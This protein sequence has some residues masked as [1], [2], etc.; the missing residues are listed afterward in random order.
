M[1]DIITVHCPLNNETRNLINDERIKMM[2]KD[3]ILV[4]EARGAVLDETAVARAIL[5]GRIG[6][7]GSD[8]YS[9]EPFD[10][11]HPFAQISGLDN[12][13]LTPHAAWGAYEARVRCLDIICSNIKCFI[14]GKIQ[15]R[16]DI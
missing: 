4:N 14:D 3:V 12:V 16:V 6:A 9:K 8:V 1:S 2:K 11:K 13:C 10:K 7:F 5:N 15:N